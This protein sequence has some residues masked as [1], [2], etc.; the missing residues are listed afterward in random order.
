MCICQGVCVEG[1]F[2]TC[3]ALGKGQVIFFEVT[4]SGRRIERG[5]R[6]FVLWKEEEKGSLSYTVPALSAIVVVIFLKPSELNT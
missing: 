5:T 2:R 1:G 4:G 3:V 6:K